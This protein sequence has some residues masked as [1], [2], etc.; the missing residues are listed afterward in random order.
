M[1]I[2]LLDMKGLA[3]IASPLVGRQK[4][5]VAM[6]NMRRMARLHDSASRKRCVSLASTATQHYRRARLEPIGFFDKPAFGARK[7]YWPADRLKVA[8][9]SPIIGEYP[10]KFWKGS[11]EAAYVHV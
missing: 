4:I 6:V 10:L 5:M 9:T 2:R 8:G 11:R 7:S 3:G 1:L